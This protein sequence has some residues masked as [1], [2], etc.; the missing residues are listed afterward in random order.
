MLCLT[1]TEAT[2]DANKQ[3]IK[4]YCNDADLFELRLDCLNLDEM[5]KAVELSHTCKTDIILTYRRMIDG[6][7]RKVSEEDRLQVLR[8]CVKNG[9]FSYID[10][11]EDLEDSELNALVEAKQMNIIRSR[12]DFD[13]VPDDVSKDLMNLCKHPGEIPKLA[14]M[15]KSVADMLRL[16]D[17][18][19]NTSMTRFILLGMGNFGVWSRILGPH[20]GGFLSYVSVPNQSAAPG[21]IDIETMSRVYPLD[22]LSSNGHIFG[23]IGNPVMHTK[24]PVLHNAGFDAAEVDAMYVPFTVDSVEDFITFAEKLPVDGFSVTI[25]HKQAIIPFLDTQTEAVQAIGACN[26]VYCKDGTLNGDNTDAPG[27][28]A[29]LVPEIKKGMKAC[30]IGAGGAARAIIYG[31][32]KAGVEVLVVN[33][34]ESRAQELAEHFNCAY[35]SINDINLISQYNDILVQTTS[36]GMV[37]DVERDPVAGYEFTGKEI[38]YDIIYK[39]LMTRFLTRAQAAGCTI[40]TGDKMLLEQGYLQFKGFTGCEYPREVTPR[41]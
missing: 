25:P 4:K 31:L 22:R 6:G 41:I 13:S 35:G 28:M 20:L 39:P 11:E 7:R 24:S 32:Q 14:V 36:L 16:L 10:M 33:R 19:R 18:Y 37:P 40:I 38:A 17:G 23:I 12:H 8:T 2:V 29:P 1:L 5:P 34:T 21:H 30:I 27:F 3:Y 26:T 15:P 9:D